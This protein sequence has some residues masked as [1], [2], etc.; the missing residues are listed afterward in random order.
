LSNALKLLFVVNVPEF[1]LSHRLPVAL[2]AKEKGYEVHVASAGGSDVEKIKAEGLIHHR[3]DFAR[4]GQNPLIELMTLLQLFRL[5]RTLRP[6]I[7]HLVTIK[8]V[9]YGGLAARAAGVPGVVAAIS[10]LGSVF[11]AESTLA[12]VRKWFI[13]RLYRL[14][15]RQQR[16][17]AIFQN[18]DDR[19]TLFSAQALEEQQARMI[20]GSGVPMSDYP[21]LPEP[22][23]VPV[24]AMAARLLRDKGVFEFVAAARIL[25]GRGI[26]ANMRL[27]GSLDPGNA[28]SVT[29]QHLTQWEEE[30]VVSLLGHRTDV[31]DQYAAANIV[32]LPSFYGEGLP[33]TLV[34]AAATGRAVVTT[35]HPGCRDAIIRGKTGLLV[36]VRDS[37]ALADA[38]QTLI[39]NPGLRQQMGQSGRELAEQEFAIEKIVAQHLQIYQDLANDH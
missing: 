34:E 36:P 38:I 27:I 26:K 20:R 7:A 18:P 3:V 22:E 11:S 32:C 13:T 35:D 1:F 12:K 24:V 19:D 17:I 29:Q 39:E 30:G 4:S 14:A 5:F 9:L 28:S 23:G 10:G 2:A 8:P 25:A 16:L 15:F 33:K 21:Y 31:A 6:E 37:V